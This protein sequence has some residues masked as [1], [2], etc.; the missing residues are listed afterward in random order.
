MQAG[1]EGLQAGDVEDSEP[2]DGLDLFLETDEDVALDI[3]DVDAPPT[4]IADSKMIHNRINL[5][6]Q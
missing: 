2:D 3:G 1:E 5:F 4:R 6:L